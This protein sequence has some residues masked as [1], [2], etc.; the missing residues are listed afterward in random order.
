V[1]KGEE[2]M[3]EPGT[4]INMIGYLS[5][6]KNSWAI[7]FTSSSTSMFLLIAA[8][9]DFNNL[10]AAAFG[11]RITVKPNRKLLIL[12]KVFVYFYCKIIGSLA[13]F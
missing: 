10:K 13:T 11:N 1:T 7:C 9:P 12:M 8:I 5:F 3:L 4:T 6:R 2:E